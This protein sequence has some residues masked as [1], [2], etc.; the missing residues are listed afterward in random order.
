MPSS[1]GIH[2]VD[3]QHVEAALVRGGEAGL[4]VGR[5]DALMAGLGEAARHRLRR[6]GVVL[7]DQKPHAPPF[8]LAT[9]P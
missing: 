7:D 6:L 4:A 9:R 3:D 8:W 1:L 5:V 2:P